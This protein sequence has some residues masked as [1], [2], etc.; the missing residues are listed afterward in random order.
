MGQIFRT[1]SARKRDR[2]RVPSESPK[3]I[4]STMLRIL[5]FCFVEEIAMEQRSRLGE[6][7][8]LVLLAILRLRPDAYG[9]AIR[10]EIEERAQRPTSLGALY[11]TLE[12]LE[13]K[14]FISSELGDVTPERGGRAK[15]FFSL[16]ASGQQA[17]KESMEAVHKMAEGYYPLPEAI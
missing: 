5:L 16:N 3:N 14:G 11:L 15:R 7:E 8:Q 17:L 9:M 13:V 2:V 1:V 6:F 4:S 12:R 10:R